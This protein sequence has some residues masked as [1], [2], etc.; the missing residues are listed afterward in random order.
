MPPSRYCTR[1]WASSPDAILLI[2]VAA[3]PFD[4]SIFAPAFV[5]AC[6]SPYGSITNRPGEPMGPAPAV[7]SIRSQ[8]QGEPS[9]HSTDSQFAATKIDD[10]SVMV[11]VRQSTIA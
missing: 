6:S 11:L 3:S 7:G 10:V 4:S 5:A 9:T 2:T 1:A 8:D